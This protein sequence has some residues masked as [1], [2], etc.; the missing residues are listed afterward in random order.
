MSLLTTIGVI[1]GGKFFTITFYLANSFFVVGPLRIVAPVRIV[2][3]MFFFRMVPNH[4]K[5]RQPNDH[6]TYMFLNTVFHLVT[7]K[8]R[9]FSWIWKRKDTN[10]TK[11]INVPQ[12][13]TCHDNAQKRYCSLLFLVVRVILHRRFCTW[14]IKSGDRTRCLSGGFLRV[15]P[16]GFLRLEAQVKSMDKCWAARP[17]WH[18]SCIACAWWVASSECLSLC[19]Y[20]PFFVSQ[21][22]SKHLAYR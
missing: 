15:P 18:R 4:P 20:H 3:S 8:T 14:D 19:V 2:R 16:V 22:S 17:L 9:T 6:S 5:I 11:L 13:W 21:A 12:T 7:V 10:S 1:A